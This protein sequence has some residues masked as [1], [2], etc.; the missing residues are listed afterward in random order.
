MFLSNK[1]TLK[2]IQNIADELERI[3]DENTDEKVMSFTEDKE[4]KHLLEQINRT[5]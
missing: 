5:L 3:L 1:I 4:F 2:Q